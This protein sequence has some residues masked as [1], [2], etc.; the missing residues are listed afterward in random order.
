MK[1]FFII[2]GSFITLILLS[3]DL[4]VFSYQDSEVTTIMFIYLEDESNNCN[5]EERNITNIVL[6]SVFYFQTILEKRNIFHLPFKDKIS[7]IFIRIESPPPNI[8]FSYF[9]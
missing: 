9:I 5:H 7:N 8:I 4:R 6:D 3:E 1:Y 2:I